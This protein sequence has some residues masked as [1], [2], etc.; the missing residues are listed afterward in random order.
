ML[1]AGTSVT[2]LLTFTYLPPENF[3]FSGKSFSLKNEVFCSQCFS[4]N[5]LVKAEERYLPKQP[6]IF[7]YLLTTPLQTGWAGIMLLLF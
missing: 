7:M 4:S 3:F 6:K 2:L 1:L 5:F